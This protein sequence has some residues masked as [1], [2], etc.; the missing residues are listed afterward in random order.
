[1]T[2]IFCNIVVEKIAAGNRPIGTLNARGCKNL[3]EKFFTQTG[4]NYTQ[5][6]LKNRWDNFKTLY[7]ILGIPTASD[8]WWETNTKVSNLSCGHLRREKK[9]FRYAP[10]PCLKQWEIMFEKSHVSGQS[11]CIPSEE[12]G[13]DSVP[14]EEESDDDP[15]QEIGSEKFTPTSSTRTV[16]K[17]KVT[18]GSPRKIS[19]RKKGKNPMV[20]VMS[21]MVD[22]VISSNSVTSK[23]LTG[24]FTR[25]SVREVMAL[26]KECG[27]VE[28]SD[29]H[30]IATQL[31]KHSANREIFFV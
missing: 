12:G 5:K 13:G 7:G 3:R 25:E 16:L 9:A 31:F 27:A 1:M 23:A 11:A 15:I 30:Y 18:S 24:D 29:E 6:Q 22:D 2:I 8:T 28:G 20:R 4:K 10:P 17:R 26:V 14:N 19:P 21:R